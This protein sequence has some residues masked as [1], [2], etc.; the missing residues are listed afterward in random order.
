MIQALLFPALLLTTATAQSDACIAAQKTCQ[1]DYSQTLSQCSAPSLTNIDP[2]N[3]Y[4]DL[5]CPCAA[6][7]KFKEW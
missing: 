5:D 7:V 6:S 2:Q 1:S 3:P 4:K